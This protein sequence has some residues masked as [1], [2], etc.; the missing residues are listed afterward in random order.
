MRA[1][2]Y[3][4]GGFSD[5]LLAPCLEAIG[6]LGTKPEWLTWVP[7]HRRGPVEN[8]ARRLAA[9]LGIPAAEAVL[10]PRPNE[11]QKMMQN[12]TRQLQN[13]WDAFEVDPQ[14]IRRGPCLL[15]DDIVD[16]GWTL[17]AIAIKLRRAGV[18]QVVPFT[19]ATARPRSDS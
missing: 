15:F 16:S 10:K 6:K 2:K 17:V 4:E 3:E 13:V 19:L 8:F 11:E 14:K 12:S 5:E 7:N 9:K 18:S 1:G